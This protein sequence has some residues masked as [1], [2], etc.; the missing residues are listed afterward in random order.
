MKATI[1][2]NEYD[3]LVDAING[4]K[5]KNAMWELDQQMRKVTKHGQHNGRDAT[6]AE[7]EI[8]EHWRE[9]LRQLIN[10]DGLNFE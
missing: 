3:E 9:T 10:N 8:T 4:W 5:W 2:F 7:I 1:E 6:E